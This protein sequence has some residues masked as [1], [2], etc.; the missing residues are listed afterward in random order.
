M[1]SG[2]V[3]EVLFRAV[4]DDD[5]IP[6][7]HQKLQGTLEGSVT[8]GQMHFGKPAPHHFISLRIN[9][10]EEVQQ[11]A[12]VKITD[13]LRRHRSLIAGLA[14]EKWIEFSTALPPEQAYETLSFPEEV[15]QAALDARCRLQN[16]CYAVIPKYDS[17]WRRRIDQ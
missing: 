14:G 16:T 13:W 2:S 8:K 3:I 9:D 15:L 11:D 12:M 17:M 4:G 6:K 7:L 1:K 5:S 10:G